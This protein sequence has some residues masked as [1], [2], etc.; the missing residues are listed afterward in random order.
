MSTA[1]PELWSLRGLKPVVPEMRMTRCTMP[2]SS[3]YRPAPCVGVAS[4]VKG[5]LRL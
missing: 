2:F 5:S 4:T 3:T 1:V